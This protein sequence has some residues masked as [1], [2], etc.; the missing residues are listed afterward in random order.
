MIRKMPRDSWHEALD[1]FSRQHEGW[2]VSVTTRRPDGQLLVEAQ[3]VPLQGISQTTPN[4]TDVAVEV[5]DRDRHLT[6]QVRDVTAVT[7]EMTDT[8]AE[9]A[10]VLESADRSATTVAFRSPMRPEEVDG[11]PINRL[12]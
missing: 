1:S 8:R 12:E 10:L 4:S 6:H 5:G 3:N 11:L 9:R 7:I 2:L